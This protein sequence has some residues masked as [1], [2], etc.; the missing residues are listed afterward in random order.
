[1]NSDEVRVLEDLDES[2]LKN[3]KSLEMNGEDDGNIVNVD[4]VNTDDDDSCS[5][6]CVE[7]DDLA[8]M[9]SD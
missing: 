4:V 2:P 6:T 9:D 3:M 8:E 5:V 1:M 7:G